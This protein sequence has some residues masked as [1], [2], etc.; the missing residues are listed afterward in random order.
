MFIPKENFHFPTVFVKMALKTDVWPH[1]I[2]VTFEIGWAKKLWNK[3]RPGMFFLKKK[4]YS[5]SP[6]FKAILFC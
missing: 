5:N 3:F 4:N 1:T 2:A 6:H